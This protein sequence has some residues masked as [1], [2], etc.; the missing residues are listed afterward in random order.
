L[1]IGTEEVTQLA[2]GLGFA[3]SSL[4]TIYGLVKKL[5]AFVGE[6]TAQ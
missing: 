1:D 2:I 4:W 6:K 5:F 3:I